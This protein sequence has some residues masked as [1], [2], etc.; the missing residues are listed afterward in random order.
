VQVSLRL[1]GAPDRLTT[2]EVSVGDPGPGRV[3][4]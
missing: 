2:L 1:I 3:R 4:P